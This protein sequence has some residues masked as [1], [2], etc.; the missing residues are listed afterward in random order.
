MSLFENGQHTLPSGIRADV[1]LTNSWVT[2]TRSNLSSSM[3]SATGMA[4]AETRRWQKCLSK[5]QI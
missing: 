1:S 5:V 2:V 4:E 3:G